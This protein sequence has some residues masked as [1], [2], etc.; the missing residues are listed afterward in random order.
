M[1]F[2]NFNHS[3]NFSTALTNSKT[4]TNTLYFPSDYPTIIKNGKVFGIKSCIG[5]LSFDAGTGILS[6]SNSGVTASNYGTMSNVSLSHGET[7]TIPY[8]SVNE[9]G[10]ITNASNKTITLPKE[11]NESYL[12][13]ENGK[14]ISNG[15]SP[16]DMAL[17]GE[18]CA[19]RLSF[20][21]ASCIDI[22]FSRDG[23][24]TWY[25]YPK[26]L[27]DAGTSDEVTTTY[28]EIP[29]SSKCSLVTSGL[30]SSLYLGSRKGNQ[31]ANDQLRITITFPPHTLYFELKKILI[32]YCRAYGKG[33]YCIVE[34][35]NFG[36]TSF[37]E[38]GKYDV[39]GWSGWNSIPC[40]QTLGGY[41]ESQT[42]CIHKIRLIFGVTGVSSNTDTNIFI[43][44]IRMYGGSPWLNKNGSLSDNNHMYTWDV[45]KNVK[46]PAKLDATEYLQN[47][48][49]LT[50]LFYGTNISRTK[51]MVLA[52]PSTDNGVATFRNLVISDLPTGTTSST[53]A[54]GDHTHSNYLTKVTASNHYTP[55]PTDTM[56]PDT[57]ETAQFG[58]LIISRI[59]VDINGHITDV[60]GSKLPKIEGIGTTDINLS[61][62][63]TINISSNRYVTN[64]STYP[65]L[66]LSPNETVVCINTVNSITI[67]G[68]NTKLYYPIEH[69]KVV[70]N[71][72]PLF[73]TISYHSS[74]NIKWANNEIPSQTFTVLPDKIYEMDFESV[75][76]GGKKTIKGRLTYFG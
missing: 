41:N 6:H 54:L 50:S 23:G 9:T 61:N 43:E 3:A 34:K 45:Y 52:A 76:I 74:L 20:I 47:N 72:S 48:T 7:F 38:I 37:T 69:Y 24:H 59:N 18:Y 30:S 26:N 22:E 4:S 42:N 40:I 25:T 51:N 56:K 62:D 10:H 71:A 39:S 55:T 68:F 32:Y 8:I 66:S 12:T 64:S 14:N 35:C 44:K 17:D 21:P 19:N 46:F 15:M 33:N 2:V 5:P 58:S 29:D 57:N 70:F 53:V 28:T 65:I 60:H 49:P 31:T 73:S 36:S 63:G 1:A 11:L 27:T 13:W 67:D 16:L 75:T